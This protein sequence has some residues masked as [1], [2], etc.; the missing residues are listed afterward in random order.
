[1]GLTKAVIKG[2]QSHETETDQQRGATYYSV[3][4]PD[5]TACPVT[6]VQLCIQR[7]HEEEI[8]EEENKRDK[9]ALKGV[10]NNF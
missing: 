4:R 1:M 2:V 8:R 7:L 9:Q 3:L 6:H 10:E 5:S